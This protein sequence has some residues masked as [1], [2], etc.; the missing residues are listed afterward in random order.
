M[1]DLLPPSHSADRDKGVTSV[2][3]P[4]WMLKALADIAKREGYSRNQLLTFFVRAA[5]RQYQEERGL[6]SSDPLVDGE[7]R[8]KK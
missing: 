7:S 5:I 3:F 4:K 1:K 6:P 8:Q 2:A